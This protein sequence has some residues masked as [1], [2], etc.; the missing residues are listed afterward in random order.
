MKDF[1]YIYI[2]PIEGSEITQELSL[3]QTRNGLTATANRLIL[4]A[5]ERCLQ[6]DLV[7]LDRTVSVAGCVGSR[8]PCPS[9]P[10]QRAA[11]PIDG[12]ASSRLFA[13]DVRSASVDLSAECKSGSLFMK[14]LSF[15]LGQET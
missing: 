11:A 9:T 3:P 4:A 5:D 1:K 10:T 15:D 8:D 14:S 6:V 2:A 7:R 13:D 12:R